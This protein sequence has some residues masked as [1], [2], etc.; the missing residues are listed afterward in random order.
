MESQ[1]IPM[2]QD[3]VGQTVSQIRPEQ[4]LVAAADPEASADRLAPEGH[5]QPK[6]LAVLD[7]LPVH[8]F[9]GYF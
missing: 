5:I 2:I 7:L 9:L 4:K 3:V 8:D 1:T 6:Y